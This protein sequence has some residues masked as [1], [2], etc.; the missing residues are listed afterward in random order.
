MTYSTTRTEK[1]AK[2]DNATLTL[3]A[4]SHTADPNKH[5]NPD[6]D[7]LDADHRLD[8]DLEETFPASDSPTTGG[9]TKIGSDGKETGT[10]RHHDV[11]TATKGAP[12]SR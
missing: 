10:P 11:K 4:T 9:V 6:R 3:R 5:E 7:R 8:K 1:Q 2:A 12:G